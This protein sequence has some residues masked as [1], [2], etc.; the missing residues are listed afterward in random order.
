MEESVAPRRGRPPKHQEPSPEPAAAEPFVM[1]TPEELQEPD[2]DAVEADLSAEE[3]RQRD[4]RQKAVSLKL[5]D[6]HTASIM[7]IAELEAMV[8]EAEDEGLGKPAP[9]LKGDVLDQAVEIIRGLL[10]PLMIKNANALPMA[11]VCVVCAAKPEHQK[12]ECACRKARM[13]LAQHAK[14]PAPADM[15]NL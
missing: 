10:A 6:E 1:A 12:R 3:S 7:P 4:L 5:M 11:N 13:F 14:A 8:K 9:P 2:T 15:P